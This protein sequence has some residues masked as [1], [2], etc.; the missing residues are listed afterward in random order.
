MVM[1][2]Q[3]DDGKWPEVTAY[4]V[5]NLKNGWVIKDQLKWWLDGN[6]GE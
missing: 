1:V 6:L 5:I 3:Q 4:L 2:S